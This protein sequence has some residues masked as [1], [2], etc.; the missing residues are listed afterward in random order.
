MTS[1]AALL[2]E[3]EDD[4]KLLT[5]VFIEPRDKDPAS[6]YKR[7]RLFLSRL[8]TMAPAVRAWH[9]PNEGRRSEFERL[10]QWR[11]GTRKGVLDLTIVWNH[12]VFFAEMKNGRDMPDKA[13]CGW[14]NWLHTAGFRCGVYRRA[15]TLLAH[16]RDA[17]APF[18]GRITA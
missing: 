7:Q 9:V 6:E 2:A 15:D 16:L 12:G 13:Q 10:N 5:G 4:G 3:P 14:L 8:A 17:G 1:L 18:I 11:L